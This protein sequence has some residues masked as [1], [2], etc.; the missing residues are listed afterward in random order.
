[1]LRLLFE[2]ERNSFQLTSPEGINIFDLLG[3]YLDADVAYIHH[4]YPGTMD[5]HGNDSFSTGCFPK[6]Q[7]RVVFIDVREFDQ[8][9]EF[10]CFATQGSTLGWSVSPDMTVLQVTIA[11][12][13]TI[14]RH[15]A[16]L[17]V[18]PRQID[19]MC[20]LA[21]VNTAERFPEAP[22]ILRTLEV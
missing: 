16:D 18:Q 22:Y 11:K 19:R 12:P 6:L 2:N 14:W 7:N 3:R 8:L 21:L 9:P 4:S 5:R 17:L 15:T 10:K 13:S 20:Q 1:M